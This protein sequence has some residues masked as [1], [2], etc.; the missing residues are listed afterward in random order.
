[1]KKFAVIITIGICFLLACKHHPITEVNT[2]IVDTTHHTVDTTHHVVKDTTHKVTGTPCS[3]DT[4]YFNNTIL[5]LVVSSCAVTG[6]HNAASHV[7]GL[8]LTTYAGI[9]RIVYG[10]NASASKL[11]T[12]ISRNKMP[13]Y[14]VPAM[15][16]ANLAL[17]QKWINQGAKNNKCT[18]STCDSVNVTYSGSIAP[19][20]KLSCT[21]CHSANVSS[22]TVKLDDYT[23]VAANA[24]NGKLMGAIMGKPGFVQMP[25]TGNHMSACNIGQIRRWIALGMPNN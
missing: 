21:G 7:E 3:P 16:A 1:M 19:M 12:E 2:L 9:M 20:M 6:C 18:E 14:P 23:N 8:N 11:Y 5:P 22:G 15:S 17:I 25:Q 13:R 4:V 24:G 10:N